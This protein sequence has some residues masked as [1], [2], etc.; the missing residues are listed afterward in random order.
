MMLSAW[1]AVYVCT[2]TAPIARQLFRRKYSI[3]GP[4]IEHMCLDS[5]RAI[6]STNSTIFFDKVRVAMVLAC[7]CHEGA[8]N[9]QSNNRLPMAND[10]W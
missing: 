5:N 10:E 6:I 8:T 2:A 9:A 1:S 3:S 4:H 7:N